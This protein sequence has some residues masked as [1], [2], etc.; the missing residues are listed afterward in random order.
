MYTHTRILKLK[1]QLA[2]CLTRYNQHPSN[3]FS[4]Q[5]NT[6]FC[7][8]CYFC[9]YCHEMCNQLVVSLYNAEGKPNQ[10]SN[11]YKAFFFV[12][13]ITSD[14]IIIYNSHMHTI[15][16]I[17]VHLFYTIVQVI[18]IEQLTYIGFLKYFF[19]YSSL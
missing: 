7:C 11:L 15:S 2:F 9:V 5:A 17:Y 6:F 19:F 1:T 13:R 14:L 3:M 16:L 12:T 18:T 10:K 8:F 4:Y